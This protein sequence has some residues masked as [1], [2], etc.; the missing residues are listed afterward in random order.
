MERFHLDSASSSGATTPT[1]SPSPSNA[2]FLSR[3]KS[4][5][6]LRRV[7]P[8]ESSTTKVTHWYH[9]TYPADYNITLLTLTDP[10]FQLTDPAT[11]TFIVNTSKISHEEIKRQ[12]VIYE[13]ISTEEAY[14]SDI[15]LIIRVIIYI[16]SHTTTKHTALIFISLLGVF[17]ATGKGKV[18]RGKNDQLSVLQLGVLASR[19]PSTN[20]IIP[21]PRLSLT[22]IPRA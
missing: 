8:A 6:G 16:M 11:N 4:I 7:T 20:S 9:V 10:F 2:S 15:Q 21:T 3:T 1:G 13:L 14:I 22:R 12:E 5:V 17:K 19:K 18:D